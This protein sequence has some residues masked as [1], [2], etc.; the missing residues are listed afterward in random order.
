MS[1][2]SNVIID[3][4][5]MFR[6]RND[7]ETDALE[8]VH[9]RRRF[10]IAPGQTAL[11]PFELIRIHWGDPRS[12][13]GEFRKFSDSRES[14]YVN[15]RELEIARLGVHYGSYVADAA[16]LI[17]PDW[18]PNDERH[19]KVEKHCPWPVTIGTEGGDIIVPVCF[20]V[21]GTEIYGMVATESADLN[22]AVQYREHLEQQ[23][24]Q[25]REQLR[26]MQG[27]GQD[28]TEVDAPAGR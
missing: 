21:A 26:T 5:E 2:A 18:P 23:L 17:D 22:D 10:N 24:D 8:L 28:D 14:G 25:I 27:A 1:V 12:R 6:L 11:V 13:Y 7:H 9:G 19:G 15:K 3:T 4:G 20:D 16:G